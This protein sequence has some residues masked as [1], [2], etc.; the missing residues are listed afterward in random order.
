MQRVPDDVVAASIAGAT[1]LEDVADGVAPLRYPSWTRAQQADRWFE[2]WSAHTVGIRLRLRTAATRLRLDA[3]VTLM[4]P[5][6]ETAPIFPAR[7]VAEVGGTEVARAE[8]TAGPL[9]RVLPARAWRLDDGPRSELELAIGG[10]GSVRDVTVW[11]PQTGATV[12]HG[13]SADAPV[14]A[15]GDPSR[16]RWLH[17]GSSISECLEA[18]TPRQ[19][20]PQLAAAALDLELDNYAVAGNAQLDPFVAR[21]LAARP[22]DVIS[23]KLGVNTIN[24]DTM[25]E[26]AFVPAL[27]GFLDLVRE[28]HPRTP[29]VVL[30]PI[31]SPAIESTPGPTVKVDGRYTGS[32]R[33]LPPGDG[34]LT[35]GR[36]RQFVRAAVEARMGSDDRLWFADGL[37]L[38]GPHDAE[39]L[40]DNLHPAQAGYDLIAE[41]FV[42]RAGVAS[43]GIGSAFAAVLR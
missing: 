39:L 11:L 28:G 9:L 3:T 5:I 19:T 32:P 8:V 35:L 22:A 43:T 33:E 37:E 12:I 2:F 15:A 1:E 27:H 10:D 20:W 25:K 26:R 34:T 41:R 4:V 24:A 29:M 18:E 42:A 30:T 31:V 38:L 6:D 23:L 40:W 36:V 13:L 16:P 7:V 21:T 14:E 17:H